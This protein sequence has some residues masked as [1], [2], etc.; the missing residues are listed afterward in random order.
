MKTCIKTVET[1]V[2]KAVF[3]TMHCTIISV[4]VHTLRLPFK[5]EFFFF[6]YVFKMILKEV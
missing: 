1:V 5:H 6:F 2:I 3:V 4:L